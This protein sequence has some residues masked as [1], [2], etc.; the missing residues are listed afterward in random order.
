M[1]LIDFP[2]DCFMPYLLCYHYD[3]YIKIV[4][5]HP[6]KVWPATAHTHSLTCVHSQYYDNHFCQ[7]LQSD[8]PI[9]L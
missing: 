4:G 7:G 8:L 3:R 5:L 9:F 6:E 2:T 1:I